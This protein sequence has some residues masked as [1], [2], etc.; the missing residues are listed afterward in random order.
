MLPAIAAPTGS[1]AGR[2][3]PRADLTA[4]QVGEMRDLLESHFEGVALD[5]FERDLQEKNWA[6][7]L[8]DGDGRIQGFSTLLLYR[9]CFEGNPV[10]VVYSGDTIVRREHWGSGAL[11]R[12]WIRSV[13]RL[14]TRHPGDRLFWLL[15]SSG[16]RTYRFLP[17]FW[18]TFHPRH[19]LPVPPDRRRLLDALAS[20]RFGDAYHPSE[21]VVRF[22]RPQVLREDLLAVPSGRR[23]DPYVAFFIERNPG[24]VRGDELVCLTEI[25]ADNLTAAGRRMWGAQADGA[26]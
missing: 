10:T 8:E 22:E 7:L 6:I 1:L 12:T 19:D 15:I 14:R 21:G 24:Y 3:V 11:S 4:G 20:E 17:L 26:G 5:V 18:R 13:N 9:T 2:L 25:A 23:A 16:Y